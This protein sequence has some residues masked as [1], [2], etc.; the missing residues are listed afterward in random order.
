MIN[1]SWSLCGLCKSSLLGQ[2][3]F[4]T[5]FLSG[6]EGGICGQRG[7]MWMY[8]PH[9]K[10]GSNGISQGFK[11]TFT[12]AVFHVCVCMSTNIHVVQNAATQSEFV[13][14]YP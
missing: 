7:W 9:A 10:R 6:E 14:N 13:P 1:I 11:Y 8:P 5:G 12:I 3:F 4:R 2:G